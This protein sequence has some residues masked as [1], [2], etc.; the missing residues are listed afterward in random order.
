MSQMSLS[1]NKKLPIF[2]L[3]SSLA[4]VVG[5]IFATSLKAA[6]PSAFDTLSQDQKTGLLNEKR[7]CDGREAIWKLTKANAQGLLGNTNG[8][9]A[10]MADVNRLIEGTKWQLIS[11]PNGTG[12]SLSNSAINPR[13]PF[14]AGVAK[15]QHD[16]GTIDPTSFYKLSVSARS[17]FIDKTYDNNQDMKDCA[18]NDSR[19]GKLRAAPARPAPG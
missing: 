1:D 12:L 16:L 2:R 3:L 14:D 7:A 4:V 8:Q 13:D 17:A 11:L 6:S 10:L 9:R 5:G 19:I 15:T 18:V